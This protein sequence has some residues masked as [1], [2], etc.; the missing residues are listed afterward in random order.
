MTTGCVPRSVA[1]AAVALLLGFGSARLA[2]AHDSGSDPNAP[3]TVTFEIEAPIDATS[4]ASAPPTVTLLGL[5][6]DLTHA[7]FVAGR[8]HDGESE[9]EDDGESDDDEPMPMPPPAAMTCADLVVGNTLEVQLANDTAPLA[10][11]QVG[12]GH[13]LELLGP[14]QMIDPNAQTLTLFGLTIDASHA[15]AGGNCG[16][17]GDDQGENES[18]DHWKHAPTPIDLTTLAV[19]QFAK[20]TLDPASLPTLVATRVDLQHV[21]NQMQVDLEDQDGNEVDDDANSVD[22]TV[23]QK[24]TVAVQKMV[25]GVAKVRHVSRTLHFQM[26]THGSFIVNGLANGRARIHVTRTTAGAT[27]Q[28]KGVAAVAPNQS[29]T[30]K[31]RLRPKRGK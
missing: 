19:G 1:V 11:T 21:G 20:V 12:P 13:E 2:V 7:T 30:V 6:I 31:L 15:T 26:K 17:G 24:A 14:I 9:G 28:G 18:E 10:A 29:N 16:G 25:H 3:P 22:V 27:S 4:C 23:D 5:P 8:S